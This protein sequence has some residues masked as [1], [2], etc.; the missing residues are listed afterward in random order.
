MNERA[1]QSLMHYSQLTFAP[2]GKKSVAQV[3]TSSYSE[4][5]KTNA[6]ALVVF[7]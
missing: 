4:I 3:F 7:R 2:D 5:Q 6:I 1:T